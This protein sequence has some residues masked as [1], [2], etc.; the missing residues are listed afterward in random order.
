MDKNTLS[1]SI[2]IPTYNGEKVIGESIKSILS[3]D[4]HNY[5]IIIQDDASTDKTIQ[6]IKELKDN[7][8]KIYYNTK[9]LGY[10]RNIEQGRRK[11]FGEILFLMAQD[12]ILA[13]GTLTRINTLFSAD[14][15][16]GAVTRPY[17][18]FFNTISVPVRAKKQLNPLRDTKVLI[19]DDPK[20]VIQ[21]VDTLDQFSGL[22]YRAK[23]MDIGFHQDIFPCHIYPFMAIFKNHPVIFMKDYTVA[24][25]IGSSQ[26]RHLSS[27]YNKSPIL[28]W[29][30][31]INSVLTTTDLKR[32]G[33]YLIRDFIAVNYVG[34][35]QIRNYSTY[36]NLLREIYYLIKFR[37]INLINP[38]FWLY[39]LGTLLVPPQILIPLVDWYKNT[40]TA[41]RL[42]NIRFN[43]TT[44]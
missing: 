2:L 36:R 23:F 33:A 20:K 42:T 4:F 15:T 1:F 43:Y 27:I 34:L 14:A 41:K 18:W 29:V 3:Q 5:E 37:K 38:R 9:N 8:I 11:C 39:S 44:K 32:V 31:M 6:V 16:I 13:T 19:S 22:A 21:V 35:V 26:T 12:D 30:E 25:R 17:Y 40:I 7:R 10:P 28:S 24:V